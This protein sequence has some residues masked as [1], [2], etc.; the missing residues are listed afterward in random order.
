MA[1]TLFAAAL[2]LLAIGVP[3]AFALAMAAAIA[4]FFGSDYPLLVVFKEM[5]TGLDSFP[6]MA[7]PFF[8]LAAELMTGGALTVVLLR[9]AAQF[10]SHLRGGLGYANVLSLTLFSGI[11]GSAMADVAGPGAMMSRM[12]DKAGYPRDY[13]AALTAST[14]IVGPIIPPSII[15]IIYALQDDNVSVG[16]LFMAGF[17]PGAL[18][19]LAMAATN[20][21]VCRRAGLGAGGERTPWRQ[22]LKNTWHA[23]PALALI[24]FI[25]AG[26][27]FGVF[28]PTEAS[29]FAVFYALVCGKW[30]YRTLQW[31]AMPGILARAALL[32][33]A[34]LLIVGASAAFAWVLTIEGI[35]QQL[36]E[37][38]VSWDLS[39]LAF[40][41]AVNVLL[42]LFGIFLE[43]LPGV[44]ILVPILAPIAA[45]L[46]IDPLHFA[47]VVIFNLT[48]GMI[49]PPVGGLLFVASVTIDVRM[50][51]LVRRLPP[52]LL[53]H[54]V[55]LV[56]LTM[57]PALSV[58]L[59]RALG[60]K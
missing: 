6:L 31:R 1:L 50:M 23:L 45:A 49:T 4:V 34:V 5:F 38:L 37:T 16:A 54:G 22:M 55:V 57:F 51:A 8:I 17:V 27:R 9:F 42:L 11:S 44:M 36:A 18:I 30:I 14:A 29:V 48:L 46:G 28:T 25:L 10:V 53:A 58:W 32:T 47:I 7:V 26:I 12:M 59:P 33:S 13:A 60:F 24:V 56:L 2:L 3:I 52:F 39:P 40:L 20:W 35:P 21:W 41:L 19:A 43:P 15:M